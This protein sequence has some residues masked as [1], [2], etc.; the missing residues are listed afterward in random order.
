MAKYIPLRCEDTKF[1]EASR[2][3]Q[4]K[5]ISDATAIFRIEGMTCQSCVRNI[6][7][8]LGDT[9]GIISANVD[10]SKSRGIFKFEPQLITHQEISNSIDDAGF[11]ASNYIEE[12]F[13]T[14]NGMTCMSCVRN[15]ESNLATK[16]G[17]VNVS[18]DLK[19]GRGKFQY[20]SNLI[21]SEQICEMIDDMGFEANILTQEVTLSVIGMKCN[22]CVKKIEDNVADVYG[23]KDIKV[24]LNEKTAVV[25]FDP[26]K[27]DGTSITQRIISLGF[28]A[29]DLNNFQDVAVLECE[30]SARERAASIE[31]RISTGTNMFSEK[32]DIGENEFETKSSRCF[33]HIQGMTCASCVAAIE[34]HVRKIKGVKSILVALMP[35]KA[36]VKYNPSDVKP[37]T[38]AESITELGFPSVIGAGDGSSDGEVELK[39]CGMTCASCVHSIESNV[40]K[41]KGVLSAS[42]S[43]GT[44]KGKFTF[45]PSVTGPRDIIE[46]IQNLGFDASLLTASDRSINYLDHKEEIKKWRTAF[47][48]STAFGVPA[49]IIMMYFMFIM[50]SPGFHHEDYCCILPGLSFENLALFCLATPVQFIGGRH[51]YVAAFRALR[52]GTSNMDVLVM[53]A[54]TISYIYSCAVVIAAMALQQHTSPMT[55]FDT[56]P[57]LIM[58]ISLGR[59]L[60]HIAKG[61]TSEALAKLISL[62]ATEATLVEIGK[63]G[64]ILSEKQISVELVHRGDLLKVVPGAKVPVD[65]KVFSGS[66]TCDE[67]LI[68][69]ESMPVLKKKGSLVIGGSINQSG[70][71]IVRTTHIGQD[72]TLAQIV[73]LV[74][75][76]QTSKAPIQQLAD[77]IAGYFVPVVALLS[78]ATLTGWIIVGYVGLEYLPITEMD[79][80]GFNYTEIVFQYAFRCALTVLAIACPCALG[81]ATPTAVMVGT[82][83]GALNGIL[84]KGAEV[85]E[86]AHKG[87]TS[88][89]LAKL[90]SLQATEATLVEI[91]KEGEI[92][93][94]KQI[95]VEL[96]HRGDLLKVVPGA[97]VPVDGKV[98]SG[99]STCDE[100]L[101]T[102]ESMPVLK[103]KGSLVIG[104]SI[105]QSGLL[106]VRTTHIG[107]DTT[108]AQIVRLV[109]E[110]QTSKAPIQQ[111]A[112]KIAGY[113]VP[114]VALLS[115]A[116]LT[117]WIIVGY[118]GLEYLPIT[119]M[120]M[121]GFNYTEIVFQYAFRCALTVLAIACPCALGLA[122][123]TAVMVG[124][125]VGALNGI[126]IK[127]AEVLENAHKVK[128][129]VFDKT[130]TIT[131]GVPTL[132]KLVVL[133]DESIVSLKFML[134]TLGTAEGGSEHPI[135]AAI[136]KF[137]KDTLKTDI[138]GKILDFSAV[139][140]CGLRCTVGSLEA[141]FNSSSNL[142]LLKLSTIW[143]PLCDIIDQ[144]LLRSSNFTNDYLEEMKGKLSNISSYQVLIGNREWMRR[145]GIDIPS[146]VDIKMKIQE[147]LG[148]TAVLCAL[149]G[150]LVCMVSVAD[151]VKPE[152]HLTVHSLKKRGLDVV[153]LTGDNRK[154]A[155]AIARQ[156]GITKVFAE[157]L[158]SH[159]VAKI[160]LLQSGNRRVAM[161]GDGIND[162]PALAQAD[163]GIAI[164][165]GTD[166]A[167]EAADVVLIRNDLLDVIGC[168]ELSRKTVKR[169]RLNFLFASIYNII[170]IPIAAG[171]FSPI[172]ITLQPWMGS[173]AM[174]LSSVSVV[175]SSLMLK[176]FRKPTKESLQ[177]PEY[178]KAMDAKFAAHFCGEEIIV[179]QGIDGGV[180]FIQPEAPS[181]A[182]T[183][184]LGINKNA[185]RKSDLLLGGD[186]ED[187][188]SPDGSIKMQTFKL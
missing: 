183:R 75:E 68:T 186:S 141:M 48:I 137:V 129:V 169:I 117:G 2:I 103:K 105:N 6:E 7:S 62:Q 178:M 28:E 1:D 167:V 43:L 106:I 96:V 74:E 139:P 143:D 80:H 151:T 113:F 158:P 112:D 150:Y 115:L 5:M 10:L 84:I 64:E 161:I 156:V 82:G 110:A 41:V 36:E 18:V 130:G 27:V 33:I 56:P 166:V 92:L 164:A 102:G 76:A 29:K 55:F 135:A 13:V 114:V 165:S 85:L 77:K 138:T 4:K 30:T 122:T 86:N 50:G 19:E 90:I 87:K 180:D 174:A 173:A 34:K 60:E 94:E 140:G 32:I 47:F 73:R 126:L 11:I 185:E 59:W 99:S 93:S 66:S 134:A 51:F 163:V 81:L 109:E 42:V 172:G 8:K 177:T 20:D 65:G 83:V 70:L 182:L 155:T 100:S 52:H 175:C 3:K 35:G 171:I 9:L 127:G 14:I 98:F 101:I 89:A 181:S 153:L 58:F 159:K 44:Q 116:T 97:K 39:I 71:L 46:H 53:L 168:L 12:V 136:T 154:T 149:N 15:I 111:L 176:L 162:S 146:T 16:K 131:H 67:S 49:M 152:A 37:T 144:S 188:E 124:T 118:V 104:G 21:T 125:G 38:I 133:Y 107:Q 121:H 123:P 63:E 142:T 184:I 132:T 31:S 170:G 40:M 22:K 54:T 25:E 187:P 147:E 57:M 23:V 91:G 17:V 26:A 95:S 69:G 119:E 78:L 108:L 24:N 148:Q 160:C 145:N 157:V 88:E 128:T 79:M 120:D 179:T 61:K 45:K 72:T